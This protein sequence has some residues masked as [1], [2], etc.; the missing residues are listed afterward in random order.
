[1]STAI[2]FTSINYINFFIIVANF[3]DIPFDSDYTF[4]SFKCGGFIK[5]TVVIRDFFQTGIY[6]PDFFIVENR[7]STSLTSPFAHGEVVG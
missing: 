1:M 6:P 7:K 5:K 4:L 3:N 2:V